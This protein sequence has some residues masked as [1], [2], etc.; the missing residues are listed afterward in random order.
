[1]LQAGIQGFLR[2]KFNPPNLA[3]L[4]RSSHKMVFTHDQG[5]QIYN[6]LREELT[7]HLQTKI[8]ET[9]VASI[10]QK[11]LKILDRAWS[12]HQSAMVM[13]RDILMPLETVYIPKSDPPVETIKCLCWIV[14]REE[15]IFYQPVRDHLSELLLKMIT[16]GREGE[17]VD[18]NAIKETCQ[19]LIALGT[20]DRWVH[21]EIFE[22]KLLENFREFS[23]ANKS[24]VDEEIERAKLYSDETTV[25]LMLE[26]LKK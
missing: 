10:N 23:S 9:V 2:K 19:M 13:I 26:S 24:K 4:Y 12:D 11:F 14:F 8:R 3:E 16:N 17:K 20:G 7:S 15:I 21:E 1:M 25:E 22:K 6:L 18:Y 5:E